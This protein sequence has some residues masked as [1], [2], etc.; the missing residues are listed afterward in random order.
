L[1]ELRDAA[2]DFAHVRGTLAGIEAEALLDEE[3]AVTRDVKAGGPLDLLDRF[4]EGRDLVSV[5][6]F[7]L[8]AGRGLVACFVDRRLG[9]EVTALRRRVAAQAREFAGEELE[10]DH[11]EAVDIPTEAFSIGR[12]AGIA[13]LLGA[14]VE[15]GADGM[16]AFGGKAAAL[17]EVTDLDVMRR[18]VGEEDVRR[19]EIAVDDLVAVQVGDGVGDVA[20]ET[21]AFAVIDVAAEALEGAGLPGAVV[22]RIGVQAHRVIRRIVEQVEIVEGDDALVLGDLGEFFQLARHRREIDRAGTEDFQS[23]LRDAAVGRAE[24]L[25]IRA[26]PQRR[27]VDHVVLDLDGIFFLQGDGVKTG[28]GYL[29]RL[30]ISPAQPGGGGF[31]L[32]QRARP[33]SQEAAGSS[34]GRE[35]SRSM[36]SSHSSWLN[37]LRARS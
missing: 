3:L 26:F 1:V 35:S 7:A 28:F 32:N 21:P 5:D 23:P 12:V 18:L 19:L 24:D 20:D 30:W 37:W 16:R 11:A 31:F 8:V 10:G 6:G 9:I 17:S 33:F 34:S 4:D 36:A 25:A 27:L 14:G 29:V 15:R 2:V 13:E 22:V